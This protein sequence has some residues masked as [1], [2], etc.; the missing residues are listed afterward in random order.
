MNIIIIATKVP[1]T[2]DTI[3]L[4]GV[5]LVC[6]PLASQLLAISHKFGLPLASVIAR[7]HGGSTP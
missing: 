2:V 6:C 5:L 7:R 4:F 1:A 3:T